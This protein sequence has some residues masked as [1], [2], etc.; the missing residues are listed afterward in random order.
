[1]YENMYIEECQYWPVPV[2]SLDILSNGLQITCQN[3]W[4]QSSFRI[5][6]VHNTLCTVDP[7][8]SE[9]H[10]SEP[11]ISECF[12]YPNIKLMRLQDFWC[13]LNRITK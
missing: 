1:M 7:H 8:I 3:Y 2:F 6:Y 4:M 5:P 12:D 13:A 9:P 10:I 11:H